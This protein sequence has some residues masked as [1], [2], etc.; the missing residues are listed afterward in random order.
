MK[1]HLAAVLAL[2]LAF[3]CAGCGEDVALFYSESVE[4]DG[5]CF[6][7]N[8]TANC[9]FVGSWEFDGDW[10]NTEITIPDSCNGI[11]VTRIGGY[12]GRGFPMPFGISLYVLMNRAESLEFGA[13]YGEH[14]DNFDLKYEYSVEDVPFVLN[15]GKNIRQIVYL[16]MDEYFPRVNED[17][18][19]T[20]LHPVVWINCSEEN[21]YFYCVD[22][23]LYNRSDDSLV[24]G[25][26]YP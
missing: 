17:G 10:S 21:K 18:S 15:I 2:L 6:V 11:P 9:C 7:I 23:K 16:D 12:R 22:G 26:A 5:F 13:I 24:A 20:F 25:F 4:E 19:V 3:L 1:K 8:K 14:P